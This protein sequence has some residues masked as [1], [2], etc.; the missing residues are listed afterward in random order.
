MGENGVSTFCSVVLDPILLIHAGNEEV[1]KRLDEK[2]NQK[3]YG[4][5]NA[6]LISGISTKHTKPG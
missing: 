6:H 1:F 5:V 4:P 3:T 2:L